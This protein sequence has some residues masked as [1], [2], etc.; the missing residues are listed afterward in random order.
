MNEEHWRVRSKSPR[1]LDL[2]LWDLRTYRGVSQSHKQKETEV[3]AQE[4]A[5]PVLAWVWTSLEYL[6]GQIHSP[7]GIHNYGLDGQN[8]K[9]MKTR[10]AHENAFPCR[11]SGMKTRI[12]DTEGGAEGAESVPNTATKLWILLRRLGRSGLQN[13]LE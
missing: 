4:Y 10:V 13:R 11:V 7:Q 12:L 6:G 1:Q 5:R 3:F 2:V 9:C 8:K